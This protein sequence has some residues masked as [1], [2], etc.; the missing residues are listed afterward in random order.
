MDAP[1]ITQERQEE[2]FCDGTLSAKEI[3]S[4]EVAEGDTDL[5]STESVRS[6]EI[7]V[8]Q[9]GLRVRILFWGLGAALAFGQAWTSRFDA[10]DNTVVYLDIGRNFLHGHTAAIVNGFWSPVYSLLF[11][12][13]TTVFKPSRYWEYP[14]THLLLFAIFLF[15]MAC[16]DY[17]LRQLL[18]FRNVL[19]A[20]KENSPTPDWVWITIGYSMFLWSTLKWTT[21]DQVTTDLM[22]AGFLYLAL[23]F[24]TNISS[25]R[26]SWKTYLLLGLS[27]GLIYLTRFYLLPICLLI[28]LIAWLI[29]KQK[30]RYVGISTATLVIVAAPYIAAI[31]TQKGKFT[32]GETASFD[33][34]V[35]VN[36][37]PRYHWQGDA[38]SRLVHPTRQIFA[39]PAAFEFKAPLKGTFPPQYDI[40]YWYQGVRP[41][42]QF[43]REMKVLGRNLGLELD[44]L[45]FSL[46][47]ILVPT[48]FLAL[49]HGRMSLQDVARYWFL[50][51]PCVAMGVLFAMVYYKPPYMAAS[52]VVV[53]LCLFCSAVII[54]RGS[55]LLPGVAVLYLIVIL[56]LVAFPPVL[57]AFD[58]HPFHS[59]NPAGPSYQQVAEAA[60]QAGLKPGD[61]IASL[62][63]SNFGPSEWAYLLHLHIV[64]EIPYIAGM[65]DGTPYCYWNTHANNFWNADPATQAQLLERFSQ[66]GAVAVLSQQRPTGPAA[67][68][69]LELGNTG[70]YLYWLSGVNQ[71]QYS[72][73]NAAR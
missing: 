21:V 69:W 31:S 70:Y 2:S 58:I 54:R 45:I 28:L 57:H 66:V 55:R 68:K 4:A 36:G 35:S 47:G 39:A 19:V 63:D 61:Q 29:A 33:Y 46:G 64:A 11:G 7:G 59:P 53:V 72:E 13:T 20:G 67:A 73:T 52:F 38:R 23:G 16:F 40:S 17:F 12:L 44:T 41:K 51:L 14:A 25:E 6:D 32:Y 27:L 30:G 60:L 50:I 71:T 43:G 15:T 18:Q 26:A 48:V 34:A 42:V 56:G 1:K 24:L 3:L 22:V 65:P 9:E 37:I 5:H 49:G 62:N 8:F 10:D